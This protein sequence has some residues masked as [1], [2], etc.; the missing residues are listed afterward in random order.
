MCPKRVSLFCG[1]L[2]VLQMF[3]NGCRAGSV[4]AAG[5]PSNQPNN[6]IPEY[7]YCGNYSCPARV[8]IIA[9]ESD[10]TILLPGIVVG[11]P[12]SSAS[13]SVLLNFSSGNIP[14]TSQILATTTS[15]YGLFTSAN[16]PYGSYQTLTAAF[17]LNTSLGVDAYNG[18]IFNQFTSVA[19]GGAITSW[20]PLPGRIYSVSGF[21]FA[22]TLES[23]G[24]A[25]SQVYRINQ[26]TFSD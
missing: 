5:T 17:V 12:L 9:L 1:S 11:Q 19:A 16:A 22:G 3:I 13:N 15:I 21:Y 6:L 2:F 4:T 18:I 8:R 24:L 10:A 25:L 7:N 26:Q 14:L 20:S 23:S